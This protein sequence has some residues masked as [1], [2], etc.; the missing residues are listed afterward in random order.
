[1]S[2][3]VFKN[4]LSIVGSLLDRLKIG[5]EK[6]Q[7]QISDWLN[8]KCEH[9]SPRQLTVGLVIFCLVFGCSIFFTIWNSL[10]RYGAK[11]SSMVMMIPKHIIVKDTTDGGISEH[12]ILQKIQRQLDSVMTS[13]NGPQALDS[14]R[15]FRPGLLDSIRAM[16]HIYQSK[17]S[18]HEK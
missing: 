3:S 4:K 12:V 15:K 17:F 10:E 16:Q 14:L 8:K 9:F 11:K 2:R 18:E 13:E 1:M 6:R 5:L 7:R